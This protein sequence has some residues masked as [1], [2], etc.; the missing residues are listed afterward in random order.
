MAIPSSQ[1]DDLQAQIQQHQAQVDRLSETIEALESERR[2][3]RHLMALAANDAAVAALSELTDDSA[4]AQLAAR[5]VASYCAQQGIPLPANLELTLTDSEDGI[6]LRGSLR[7]GAF[8]A[9]IFW[10]AKSGFNGR[11]FNQTNIKRARPR[12][13]NSS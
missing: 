8:T 10:S 11:V 6:Q 12:G 9:D 2:L 3:H 4:L 7:D 5:D 13:A 1:I